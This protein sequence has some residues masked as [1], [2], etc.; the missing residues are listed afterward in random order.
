VIVPADLRAGLATWAGD[1]GAEWL[2]SLPA[3]VTSLAER[4]SLTVGEPYVP[5]GYTAL[6]LRV[7]CADGTPGVLKVRCPVEDEA[8]ESAALRHFG[9]RAAVALLDADDT[10]RA[11]LLERCDPGTSLLTE[12]DDVAVAEVCALLPDLWSPAPAGHPFPMVADA[13]LRWS[14]RLRRN[15]FGV[16]AALCDETLALLEWLVADPGPAMVLHGDLHA[17]NVLRA[18]RRP[19]LAID[20]KGR[21]GEAAYDVAPLIRDRVTAANVRC[22]FDASMWATPSPR[23]STCTPRRSSRRCPARVASHARGGA[24]RVRRS[25]GDATRGDAG[26]GAGRA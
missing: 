21:V 25:R 26:P 9:G 2:A 22:R 6:A 11:L 1:A 17:A 16:P 5:S 23:G 24:R 3:L 18:R 12:P 19:W 10:C 4:W 15:D 13:A 7:T 14:E 20:P 8:V